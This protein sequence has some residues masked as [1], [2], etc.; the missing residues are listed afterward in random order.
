M[1]KIL[2]V[3]EF[4]SLATGYS[5]YGRELLSRLHKV[6]GYKVAEFATY[7]HHQDER[8][9]HIPWDVYC[10]L[11]EPGNEEQQK[12]YQSN[13]TNVFGEWRF[14][15]VCL[16]F[17]PDYVLDI[18]DFWMMEFQSRSPFRPYF[19]WIIMPTVDSTPQNEQWL[20][21]FKSAE[22]VLTYTDWSGKVLQEQCG[23]QINW[24][25]SA[26]PAASPIYQ[27]L[28]K[29]AR[30][31][32]KKGLG[33]EP[34][35]V[36]VGTVMRNQRRK[37]Y[38]EL[39]RAFREY[40]DR[41]GDEKT[42]L[43]C[44][45]S[46]PDRGW[47]IPELLKTY[48]LGNRVFFTYVCLNCGNVYPTMFSDARA[49]C[50]KCGVNAARMPG[51]QHGVTSEVLAEIMGIF[52]LYV[53]FANCEGFGMP[54]VEAAACGV[55]VMS[56]DYSAM[57]DVVRKVGGDPIDVKVLYKELETGCL[58]AIPDEEHFVEL[59]TKFVNTPE[60]MRDVKR[61]K[62]RSAFEQNYN[63]DATADK[64]IEAIE[65]TPVKENGWNSE[66]R[67]FSPAKYDQRIAQ[68]TTNSEYVHW[69]ITNVLCEHDQLYSHMHTRLLR[70][71]NY[72]VYL[73]GTAGMYYN[74][75]SQLFSNNQYSDFSREKA[76]EMMHALSNRR[77]AWEQARA[78]KVGI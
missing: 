46:Y 33:L 2:M 74:E 43:Y 38:P 12:K 32:A 65:S 54:Q 3:N 1:K 71:L 47:D 29:E 75:Q 76:Y 6:P 31:A 16:D 10:N 4:S 17:Q 34:D 25:G 53:Q 52:D 55:P 35:S 30:L 37:R 19:N 9:Q 11:P 67:L 56:T 21:V 77:N 28:S 70:D 61:M 66:P 49:V 48:G 8:L 60:M 58:R 64:W 20:S 73:E 24:F 39:F 14:E 41:T 50:P 72:G 27:P 23:D 42:Y 63:W 22:K 51:V 68:E 44:H 69:L 18:R 13:P 62:T 36:L 40:I 45:T 78:K 57:H 5:T 59:L 7:V 26:S 15:E